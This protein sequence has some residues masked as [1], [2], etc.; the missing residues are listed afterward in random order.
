MVSE[1]TKRKSFDIINKKK[2]KQNISKKGLSYETYYITK[3][4]KCVKK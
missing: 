3:F 2:L 4:N 1:Y